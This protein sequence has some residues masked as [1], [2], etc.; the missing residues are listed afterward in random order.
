MP[1]AIP[2]EFAH[3]PRWGFGGTPELADELGRL[4]HEGRKTATCSLHAEYGQRGE[5]LPVA[6]QRDI[7]LDGAG[8]PL[9]VIETVDVTVRRAGDV[10][11]AF[12]FAEGE[13][14]RSLDYWRHAH[15][16]FFA[17][18][19]VAMTDDTLLVCESFVV[20]HRF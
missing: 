2:P 1:I 3:L 18:A 7:V 12:A 10:D 9:C 8:R 6:G 13:G 19:G 11:A 16:S 20:V 15:E 14:D 5:P 4:V 17:R